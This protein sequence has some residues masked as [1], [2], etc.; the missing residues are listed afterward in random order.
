MKQNPEAIEGL[1]ELETIF[2]YFKTVKIDPKYY[3]FAPFI[4]R[5]LAYYTG[6]IWEFEVLEGGVGSV[7]GCGRYDNTIGN[8]IG[9]DKKVPATGGSF[10]IERIVEVIKDR[11]MID[12]DT[13]PVK[14]LVT[15]FDDQTFDQSLKTA[16]RLRNN[17]ISC[18]LYP[19]KDKLNIQLKYANQKNIPFV[20][21]IGEDE[22]KKNQVT[23]KDM[24]AK[25]Q[26]TLP[27]DKVISKLK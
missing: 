15:W 20:I 18:M 25:S 13:T 26:S 21:L 3:Q 19:E 7:A 5:G 9:S 4:A 17:N 8:L 12:I 6:P 14:V 23:L 22:A 2:N 10:G 16:N 27:L 24:Q 11:K 1:T